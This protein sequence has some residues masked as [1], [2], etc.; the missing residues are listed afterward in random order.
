MAMPTENCKALLLPRE[1]VT[2]TSR[3]P[4]GAFSSTA[5]FMV[6]V[7]LAI[8]TSLMVTPLPVISTVVTPEAQDAPPP[9]TTNPF[10]VNVT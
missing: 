9:L 8:E 7:P 3:G 4:V 2:V 1:F 5:N 6:M 10:P